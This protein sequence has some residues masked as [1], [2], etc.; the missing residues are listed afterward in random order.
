M[1]VQE[2][3]NEVISFKPVLRGHKG[4]SSV[5]E[6][7]PQAQTQNIVRTVS[8]SYS[9]EVDELH[10]EETKDL[11][12]DVNHNGP[13][14]GHCQL[15]GS[16]LIKGFIPAESIKFYPP[17]SRVLWQW[18][19]PY[20]RHSAC[21][22]TTSVYVGPSLWEKI[23]G[24]AVDVDPGNVHL[25]L[26]GQFKDPFLS[27]IVA[28]L[29]EHSVL[30]EQGDG[31]YMETLSQVLCLHLMKNYCNKVYE[32]EPVKS[33]LSTRALKLVV[34]YI[35]ENLKSRV[36]LSQLASIAELSQFHF[37]R[38]FKVSTGLSPRQYLIECRL[39]KARRL[40]K[41]TNITVYSIA[42]RIGYNDVSNFVA[43][44][45]KHYGVTPLKFRKL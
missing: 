39:Q 29:H 44:F 27:Q 34:E 45:K 18:S 2:K 17:E 36:S 8:R 25:N 1:L 22:E 10:L 12:I 30:S 24:E 35:H 32:P 3:R 26:Q 40:L 20:K 43:A 38:L 19:A 5:Q 11:T 9:W 15:S 28:Q 42:E 13:I 33:A 41:D 37:S 6:N 14:F 21:L 23:I 31:M 16:T 7:K 4:S